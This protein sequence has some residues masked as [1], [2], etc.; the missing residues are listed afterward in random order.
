M[1]N[2]V[3]NTFEMLKGFLQIILLEIYFQTCSYLDH[4]STWENAQIFKLS[5]FI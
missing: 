4:K 5:S 1:L 3:I 2:A